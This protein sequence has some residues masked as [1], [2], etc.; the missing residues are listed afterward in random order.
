MRGTHLYIVLLIFF[1]GIS[2]NI[3][4]G[5]RIHGAVIGGINLS[6]VDGDEIYGFSKLGF[7]A[8]L[9]AIV[10]VQNSFIFSIE[11]VFNQKGSF[12]SDKYSS[13]DS[14]GNEL[15]GQYKLMLNYLEVPVLFL[16]ND[17]DVITAGGGFSF[18]RLIDV[19]ET[20]H[21]RKIEST[22]LNTGPYERNDFNILADIRFRIFKKTNLNLRYAY[23][24]N[25][26]RTRDF[27]DLQGRLTATRKQYNNV[28]SL[29]LVYMFNEKP[30]IA[31][32]ENRESGF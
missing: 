1:I 12:Q 26:I 15:T 7:N 23:S 8:G 28:I 18:G 21:G 17:K 10:P 20:E 6:Q 27:Y 11:T 25:K 16:Y 9:A 4:R 14:L 29:R 3:V 22:S 5:Q 30:P 32:S 13:F 31:D 24:M 2:T 19:Q